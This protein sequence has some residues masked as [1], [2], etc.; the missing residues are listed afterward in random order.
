MLMYYEIAFIVI[1]FIFIYYLIHILLLIRLLG[2]DK[3]SKLS[4]A[5]E[6]FKFLKNPIPCLLFKFGLKD[7]VVVKP[8]NINEEFYITKVNILNGIMSVL[9]SQDNISQEF[10]D[11]IN[12]LSSD[13]EVISWAG[14]N[15]LNFS[16][17]NLNLSSFFEL[18][19]NGYWNDFGID[20]SNRC[21][22]DIGSNGGDSSLYFAVQG[23]DVY[24]YEPVKP[25]YEYSLELIKLN[26]ELKD[27]LHFFNNGVSDKKGVINIS[28]M[29]S[30]SEYVSTDSYDVEVI[31]IEDI[32]NDNNISPDFL[33]MDCEGCEFNII[34]NTDLSVFRD[35]LFEH[36]AS[37]VGKDYNMLIEKLES[38]GFEIK[39]LNVF[40][41]DFENVGLIHAYK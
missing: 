7:S 16:D 10:I 19:N 32:L 13:K 41:A 36:H 18:F 34:L 26:P 33:K 2:V 20:Y 22:I 6:Y 14:A 12:E 8:K 21:I 38:E 5:L 24:G 40:T 31:T 28:S 27:R 30:V 17:I 4:Y 11:F 15:I 9:R 35:V 1:Q 25:I 3:I 29:D 39:K 23:A 37:I